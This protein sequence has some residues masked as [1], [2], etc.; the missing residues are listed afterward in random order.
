MIPSLLLEPDPFMRFLS[1]YDLGLRGRSLTLSGPKGFVVSGLGSP[2]PLLLPPPRRRSPHLQPLP[3]RP[4]P[5][6]P[7]RLCQ[8]VAATRGPAGSLLSSGFPTA[9][10]FLLPPGHPASAYLS[11]HL[12]HTWAGLAEGPGLGWGGQARP[13][14]SQELGPALS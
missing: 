3:A 11:T 1:H 8:A 13:P 10:S 4:P 2:G 7:G 12:A 6:L 14:G 9:P 5:H